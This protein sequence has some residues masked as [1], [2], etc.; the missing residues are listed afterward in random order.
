MEHE[1]KKRVHWCGQCKTPVITGTPRAVCTLCGAVTKYMCA[2]IRPVFPEERLLIEILLEKPFAFKNAAVWASGRGRYYIDGKSLLIHK[3]LYNYENA[4]YIRKKL[5]KYQLN[6]DYSCFNDSITR[7]VQANANHL[8]E[9]K[10]E[11]MEFTSEVAKGYLD[12]DIIISFSG[13]KDSTVCA[14]VVIKALNL[15]NPILFFSDTTL[16]YPQTHEYIARFKKCNPQAKLVTARNDEQD[17]FEMCKDIGVPS[18]YTRWCCT[19]FKTGPLAKVT[20]RLYNKK[21]VLSFLGIRAN[22]SSSRSKYERLTAN[23]EDRKIQQQISA[24]PIFNWT[25]TDVWLYIFSEKL[26]FN[27][28]YRIGFKRVGCFLCPNSTKRAVFLNYVLIPKQAHKWRTQLIE[29]ANEIGVRKTDIKRYVDEQYWTFRQGGSGLKASED[30]VVKSI[31]C[32]TEEHAQVYSLKRP[33]KESFYSLFNPFGIVSKE[34]GRKLIGEV[35]V[36]NEKSKEPILS[37]QPF[38]SGENAYSVKIKVLKEKGRF[39]LQRKVVYQIR[40][41]NACRNCGKC[42]NLCTF[43]AVHI[44]NGEYNISEFECK[45]CKKCVNP[46]YLQGGCEMNRVLKSKRGAT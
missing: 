14:D 35:L 27:D 3:E 8:S 40:K 5:E 13:G 18:R 20:T 29:F 17:F 32:T 23:G 37:I 11:A 6:N 38:E 39:A 12:E 31:G 34:Q 10:Q 26:D 41:Y 22:E 1:S 43:G 16:E 4:D 25:G 44:K 36:L 42:D 21:T 7:F 46:K 33:I 19:M 28:A 30:V 15:K 24:Y 9:I 45:R 2:D